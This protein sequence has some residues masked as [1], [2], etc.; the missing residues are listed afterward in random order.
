MLPLIS[1]GLAVLPKLPE[2]WNSIAGL[3]GKTAPKSV[4]EAAKLASTIST[5]ISKKNVPPETQVELQKIFNAHEEKIA[6]LNLERVKLDYQDLINQRELSKTYIQS[7]DEYVR[8]TR[9]KILRSLF[10]GW[11]IYIFFAPLSI[12]A[13]NVIKADSTIIASYIGIIKS[14]GYYLSGVFCISYTGYA[15]AR[16]LDKRSP[17]LKDTSNLIG[18]IIG[19]VL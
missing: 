4:E 8:R 9:P 7:S 19:K 12:L 15:A 2:I 6:E 18:N 5:A 13:L 16:S 3:F 14:M 17:N 1:A 11:I 10:Y